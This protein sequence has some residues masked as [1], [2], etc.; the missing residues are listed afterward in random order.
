MYQHIQFLSKK[1]V[2]ISTRWTYYKG[3]KVKWAILKTSHVATL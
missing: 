1:L 3:D 2:E